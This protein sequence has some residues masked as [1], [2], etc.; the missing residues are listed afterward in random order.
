MAPMVLGVCRRL[1]GNTHDADDPFQATFS[2]LVYKAASL[3]SRELVGNWLY[4]VA[5]NTALAARAKDNTTFP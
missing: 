1:L 3:K 2:I 4:G 5:Y